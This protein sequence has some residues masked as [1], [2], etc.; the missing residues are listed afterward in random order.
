MRKKVTVYILLAITLGYVLT[1]VVPSTLLPKERHS[2]ALI[3]NSTTVEEEAP[4][5]VEDPA[6]TLD[7]QGARSMAAEAIMDAQVSQGI[8]QYSAWIFD[9]LIALTVYFV[10]RRRF[11]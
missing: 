1:F 4:L 8:W 2:F 10:A 5:D 9:L 3:E 7:T 11:I 6:S